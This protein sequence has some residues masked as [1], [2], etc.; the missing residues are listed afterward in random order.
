MAEYLGN[1]ASLVFGSITLAPGRYTSIDTD[2]S[3]ALVDKS[4]GSDTHDS[5]LAALKSGGATV[6]FNANAGDTAT[7]NGVAPGTEGTLTYGPEGTG[8]GKPKFTCV[9][10]VEN[11]QSKQ[12]FN[13]I[14]R[15]TVSLKLQADFTAGAF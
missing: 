1:N 5:F 15:L 9:A 8:N 4:A 6:N 7:W 3:T 14:R 11:R 2:E 12:P 13:D 10:I